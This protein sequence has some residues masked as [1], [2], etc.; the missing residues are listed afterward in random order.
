MNNQVHDDDIPPFV[1]KIYDVLWWILKVLM[2]LAF[3]AAIFYGRYL[4]DRWY[5]NWIMNK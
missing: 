3:I 2:V 4:F 5:I 1:R